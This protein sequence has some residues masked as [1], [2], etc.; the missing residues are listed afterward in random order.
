MRGH[1]R[2]RATGTW[3]IVVPLGLDPATGRRRQQWTTHKGTRKEA[4]TKLTEILRQLDTG[5][6]VRPAKLT[7]GEFLIRW[8]QEYA[9]TNVRPRTLEGYKERAD[10]L[11]D[12]LGNIPLSELKPQHIRAYY[13]K[14]LKGGR[15]DNKPGGLS[16]GTL[17]KH[18]NLLYEALSHAVQWGELV[19]N[20]AQAVK[21]PKP[22]RSEPKTLRR[23]DVPVF[24]EAVRDHHLY[25]LLHTAL[26]TGMRR[27]E[28]LGLTWGNVDLDL[29]TLSVTRVLH[30]LRGGEFI[31]QE[32]KTTK[33]RRLV[34]LAPSSCSVLRDH[35]ESQRA[36][37]APIG[38]GDLVFCNPDGSPLIPA[39]VTHT[40][41]KI[42][43]RAGFSGVRLHDLRHSHASLM[44]QNG[45][46]PK[47]VQERLGHSSIQIT[48][49][50]Y[51]HLVPG[52]Q[53]QAA[54]RF[55]EG[56]TQP[57]PKSPAV[58]P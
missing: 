46:H 2:Q 33:G 55:D 56:L 23:E 13:S 58:V 12:G 48:L 47:I 32:P 52:L 41:T 4:E 22:T 14:K 24:L 5:E 54:L 1:I 17:I 27:S 28:L 11:V 10:H 15:R 57:A 8:L 6:F 42:A 45:I 35:L 30:Q 29:A 51:S 44:L 20:V 16:A 31:Y 19:K 37:E 3:T 39:V 18:H 40:F 34:D 25:S 50:T 38:S 7:V 43:Q 49:D 9:A 26:W 53:R 36:Y 21:P